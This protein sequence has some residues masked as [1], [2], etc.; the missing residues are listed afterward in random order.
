MQNVQYIGSI[1]SRRP[2]NTKHRGR[3]VGEPGN[4]VTLPGGRP[5]CC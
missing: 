4:E 1:K 3:V 5:V 2:Q